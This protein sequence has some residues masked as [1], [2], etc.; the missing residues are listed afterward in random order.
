LAVSLACVG[1]HYIC[2]Y[3][4]GATVHNIEA[5]ETGRGGFSSQTDEYI[6]AKHKL[7]A[8]AQACGSDLRSV[9]PREM[10]GLF[11]GLRATIS[12]IRI[13]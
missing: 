8:L 9:T 7:P 5:T 13:D 10:L 3:D 11:L 4:D 1:P 2:R 12:R 6:L